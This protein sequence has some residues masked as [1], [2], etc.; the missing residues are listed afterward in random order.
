[1]SAKHAR[2]RK[3]KK[4]TKRKNEDGE[5]RNKYLEDG[6]VKAEGIQEACKRI[7]RDEAVIARNDREISTISTD[8]Q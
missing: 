6:R 7:T 2:G 5:S 8:I 3:K 1:M 4:R